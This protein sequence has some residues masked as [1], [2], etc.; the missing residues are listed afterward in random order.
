MLRKH[1]LKKEKRPALERARE[2]ITWPLVQA[3]V[4]TLS[5][6]DRSVLLTRLP[7]HSFHSCINSQ[8]RKCLSSMPF[9]YKQ[10]V[11]YRA[12]LGAD[13]AHTVGLSVGDVAVPSPAGFVVSPC[14]VSTECW[15]LGGDGAVRLLP[16]V[17]PDV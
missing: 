4:L 15:V 9:K 5:L 8:P 17:C 7:G 12:S 14:A 13:V 11:L 3:S 2:V 6:L 1:L 10:V 16:L